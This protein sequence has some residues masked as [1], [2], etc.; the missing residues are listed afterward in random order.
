MDGEDKKIQDYVKGTVYRLMDKS[1]KYQD[2][3]TQAKT[4]TK[5]EYF[6]KKLRKNNRQLSDVL[7][8]L[9]KIQDNEERE[10][11]IHD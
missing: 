5:K 6:T 11:K 3:I 4:K 1:K 2:K 10:E 7:I 8:A 9:K